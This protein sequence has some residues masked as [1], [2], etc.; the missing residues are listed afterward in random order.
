MKIL[1]PLLIAALL[2]SSCRHGSKST[3]S[4][5][6]EA[7]ANMPKDSAAK[8]DSIKKLAPYNFDREK[9]Y[10][11]KT[12]VIT[13]K[14]TGD[15]K[16]RQTLYFR[17]YGKQQRVEDSFINLK[18]PFHNLTSQVFISASDKFYFMD[19]VHHNGY[20]VKRTDTTYKLQ[21][22]LLNQMAKEGI[23][24]TMRNNG[25]NLKG[26]EDISGKKCLIYT[27][28]NSKFCFY[29]GINIKTDMLGSNFKYMLEAVSIQ[30]NASVADNL[31]APDPD[32][33]LVEYM[34]Y[35]KAQTK[36]KL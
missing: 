19:L 6:A 28:G 23:E 35:V 29:N 7:R 30:D 36:D 21:G 12:G 24:S 10:P 13:Y 14:Y 31:F 32:F 18:S 26:V 11:F 1:Y 3:D 25:Y 16:G 17:D 34:K 2:V 22:N 27:S 4:A 33:T 8:I 5:S 15:Y 20:F 9:P